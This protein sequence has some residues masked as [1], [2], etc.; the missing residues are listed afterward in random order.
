MMSLVGG[1]EAIQ[2]NSKAGPIIFGL[3][4]PTVSHLARWSYR[5]A[6]FFWLTYRFQHSEKGSYYALSNLDEKYLKP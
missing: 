4:K 6:N 3:K 2:G 5:S 1:K